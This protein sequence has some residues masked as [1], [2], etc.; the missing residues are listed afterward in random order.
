MTGASTSGRLSRRTLL[1]AG[2]GTA[3]AIGIGTYAVEHDWLPRRP[4]LHEELGPHDAPDPI[5][6]LAPAPDLATGELITGS[7]R[8]AFREGESGWAIA[9][10]PGGLTGLP[11]VVALHQLRADHRTAFRRKMRADEFLADHVAKGRP[12][13][14]IATIDGGLTYWHPREDGEDTSAMV[15]KEFLPL[16][17]DHGLRTDRIGL[18]GWSMGGYGALRLAGRLGPRRVASVC[19]AGP[20][21]RANLEDYPSGFESADAYAKHT[22]FGKQAKLDGIPVR[23]DCGD[24]DFFYRDTLTYAAGFDRKIVTNFEPGEHNPEF[25]RRVLPAQLAFLGKHFGK[26]PD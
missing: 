18:I 4:L 11:V 5:T 20:A 17:A 6:D 16:L 1:G 3:A 25:W 19:A 7:L 21:L 12:P 23:I 13:F 14:A 2:L 24:K 15:V 26:Q 10:P 8:S 9:L 22:I